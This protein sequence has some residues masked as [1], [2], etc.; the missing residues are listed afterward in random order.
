MVIFRSNL[1][2][3]LDIC[4]EKLTACLLKKSNLLFK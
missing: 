4:G 3:E 1:H 2:K